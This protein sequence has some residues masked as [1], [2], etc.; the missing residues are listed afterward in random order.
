MNT[1]G[2]VCQH[3]LLRYKVNAGRLMSTGTCPSSQGP[4]PNQVQRQMAFQGNPVRLLSPM[5]LLHPFQFF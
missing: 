2:T 3:L 4:P 5:L 1:E